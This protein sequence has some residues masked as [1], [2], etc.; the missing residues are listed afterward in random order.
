MPVSCLVIA[1]FVVLGSS[2]VGLGGK[3]VVLSN[4]PV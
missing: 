1:L 3:L 4:F 2:A